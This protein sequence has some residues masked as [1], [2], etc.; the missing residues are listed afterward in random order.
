MSLSG[1]EHQVLY[2]TVT[3]FIGTGEPVGSRT[4]SENYHLGLSAA[5]IRNVLKDLEEA[6]YLAQPHKSA[7]RM[8]T[9]AAYQVYID[10]LM[11]VRKLPH[12]DQQR[13]RELIESEH[14][15]PELL[16]Q[17]GRLLSELSGVPS[18]IL[19]A[20][21]ESR[22]VQ[23]IRFIPTRPGELLSV[24]VLDDGSVENRYISVEESLEMKQLERVHLLLDEATSGKNLRELRA[25]LKL[26]AEEA[27][28]EVG[29]LSLLSEGLLGS[30][31][32]AV[33]RSKEVIIEGRASLLHSGTDPEGVRRLMVALEDREQLVALLNRTLA[34]EQ[35][36]VFLGEDLEVAGASPLSVVAAP[37]RGMGQGPAGALGVLGPTRMNYP[38]LVPLVGAMARA[39]SSALGEKEPNSPTDEDQVSAESDS[40]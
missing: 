12:V 21:S 20:R 8:P 26:L 15:R 2:A 37:Y 24:V 25:Y 34:S 5:T 28:D 33:E 10:A 7:G 18:V 11:R 13:I 3:E 27:R 29:A 6:G 40:H 14:D 39:M 31:L 23:K 30:A 32:H 35:V 36:Q 19:Q 9:R 4:L 38:E 17:S 22:S 1:R 16:R